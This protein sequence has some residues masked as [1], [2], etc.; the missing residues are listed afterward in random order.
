MIILH[1]KN[2][3][4][5]RVPKTGS[6]SLETAIR[7]TGC[8]GDGDISPAV[9][10]SFLEQV[11]LPEDYVSRLNDI[12]ALNQSIRKK[13][14]EN[15]TD[16]TTEEQNHIDSSR[17]GRENNTFKTVNLQHSTLDAL[18]D[19]EILQPFGFLTEEQIYNYNHY[20]FIRNP[21]KRLISGVIFAHSMKFGGR[22]VPLRMEKFHE[23]V[24]DEGLLGLV[25]RK[26]IDYFT[27]KGE[28]HHEGS[29]IVTPLLF[30][31][32]TNEVNKTIAA[33]GG[34]P[35]AEI[36]KFK[37]QHASR[38]LDEDKPTIET[39]LDPYPD[40]KQ[41]ILDFYAEDVALWEET[42]GRTI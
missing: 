40:V 3:T 5:M 17:A 11:N 23:Q 18:T 27:Y 20:A 12:A 1:S 28:T 33:L 39:W 32:Y 38:M 41:A 37:S 22:A 21:L 29:R 4:I 13:R 24:L 36:P 19:P 6:T 25:Y 14:I 8:L 10:D 9:E 26:Q 2:A 31:D 42:S 15:N 34:T 16:Y 7:M 30:E 35:L